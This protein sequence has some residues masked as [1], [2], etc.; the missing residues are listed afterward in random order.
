MDFEVSMYTID[1]NRNKKY[2]DSEYLILIS[3]CTEFYEKL[4]Q[5]VLEISD[6][7]P[8][9][10]IEFIEEHD[11]IYTVRINDCEVVREIGTENF[12]CTLK[13]ITKMM[14]FIDY[15]SV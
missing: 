5:I 2:W 13:G 14:Y 1:E 12:K 11:I 7:V 15:K 3:I 8:I 4:Y 6:A 9:D 10:T